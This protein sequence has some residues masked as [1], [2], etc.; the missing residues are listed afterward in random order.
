MHMAMSQKYKEEKNLV[1]EL[2]T[3]NVYWKKH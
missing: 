1:H 3:F 2:E